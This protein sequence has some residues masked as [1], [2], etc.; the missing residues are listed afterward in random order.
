MYSILYVYDIP[1]IKPDPIAKNEYFSKTFCENDIPLS[2][3]A[4]GEALNME[5]MNVEEEQWRIILAAHEHAS[6]IIIIILCVFMIHHL[7]HH[8]NHNGLNYCSYLRVS[9]RGGACLF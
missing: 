5:A 7:V 2:T 4:D 1:Q 3:T 6:I 9:Y 8:F